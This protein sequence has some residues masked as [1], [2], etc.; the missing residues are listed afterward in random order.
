MRLVPSAGSVEV[1]LEAVELT[2]V[3]VAAHRDVEQ[4]EDRIVPVGDA[5][6][7]QDH[8][9]AGAR[10]SARRRAPCAAIGSRRP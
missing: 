3:A 8:A 9:G 5:L 1:R 10:A 2:A 4:A 7:E 6:G